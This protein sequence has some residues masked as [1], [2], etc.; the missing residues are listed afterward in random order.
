MLTI[1]QNLNHITIYKWPYLSQ[2]QYTGDFPHGMLAM[3]VAR[4]TR[5]PWSS[6]ASRTEWARWP[7]SGAVPWGMMEMMGMMEM[8]IP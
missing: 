8:G 6:P 1:I 2:L 4:W 5:S 7:E 3:D